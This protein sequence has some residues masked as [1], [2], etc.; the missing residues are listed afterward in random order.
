M[1]LQEFLNFLPK[2]PQ[3]DLMRFLDK[4]ALNNITIEPQAELFIK[5]LKNQEEMTSQEFDD[6]D[7]YLSCIGENLKDAIH[8]ILRNIALEVFAANHDEIAEAV[9]EIDANSFPTVTTRLPYFGLLNLHRLIR[10]TELKA[11]DSSL[12]ETSLQRKILLYEI[13]LGI[14][15]LTLTK[16]IKFSSPWYCGLSLGSPIYSLPVG[17][18]PVSRRYERKTTHCWPYK[19]ASKFKDVDHYVFVA[20]D[21]LAEQKRREKYLYLRAT[22]YQPQAVL[23]SVIAGFVSKK[24]FAKETPLS[25]IC[26]ASVNHPD[27]QVHIADASVRA[28]RKNL[29][30]NE[31]VVFEGTGFIDEVLNF[32][33]ETDPNPENFGFSR[34]DID[35][36]AFISKIDY[37]MCLLNAPVSEESYEKNILSTYRGGVYK[38]L[39]HIPHNINY[40]REKLSARLTLAL[41]SDRCIDILIEHSFAVYGRDEEKAAVRMELINRRDI[42]LELFLKNPHA[43]KFLRNDASLLQK[44]GQQ[45]KDCVAEYCT[46]SALFEVF[47]SLDQRLNKV[48][49]DI[50]SKW[51]ISYEERTVIE[52]PQ[53]SSPRVASSIQLN[54]PNEPSENERLLTSLNT[55][56]DDALKAIEIKLAS[57]PGKMAKMR[58]HKITYEDEIKAAANIFL[59]SGKT[60]KDK[61]NFRESLCKA[62]NDFCKNALGNDRTLLSHAKRILAELSVNIFTLLGTFGV[63]NYLHYKETGNFLFF[64]TTRSA[65]AIGK[66]GKDVERKL[67]MR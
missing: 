38:N 31:K 17:Q 67:L 7:A 36:D 30:E 22:T 52:P 4:H 33:N 63:K 46:E 9:K 42:A 47:D 60:E 45:C 20:F 53:Q 62:K 65:E 13:Q 19:I 12:G 51:K 29:I 15:A 37:D 39:P 14:N 41:L 34:K 59:N 27:Y 28:A 26:N 18:F 8:F 21:S 57:V 16:R 3:N 61:S 6:F 64:S 55:L 24:H 32:I 54:L 25:G 66:L 35:R 10:M 50:T 11:N 56:I 40:I 43:E 58:E 49:Q 2:Y 48:K 5:K 1:H 23:A 44:L